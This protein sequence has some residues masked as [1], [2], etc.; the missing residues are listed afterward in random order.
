M[1]SRQ[2][3]MKMSRKTSSVFALGVFSLMMILTVAVVPYS[4][5]ESNEM[6]ATETS[7]KDTATIPL[8]D[9]TYLKKTVTTLNI[10]EDNTL[11]WAYIDGTIKN[12]AAG[13]PVIIQFFNEGGGESPIHV[14]QVD[15]NDDGSYEYKFRVRDVNLETGEA[16]NIFEGRYTI[17]IFKVVT[18]Q[19]SMDAI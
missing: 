2:K 13:H 1:G 19:N 8:T 18:L 4:L 17:K 14:A 10:P 16:T 12:H 3:I 5:A 9:E 11:P 15:V 7:S 6:P